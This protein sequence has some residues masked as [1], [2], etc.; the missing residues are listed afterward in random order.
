MEGSCKILLVNGKETPCEAIASTLRDAGYHCDC[1]SS[2][3][4]IPQ[5]I[6]ATP[7]DLLVLDIVESG[8]AGRQLI[9]ET[10]QVAGGLPIILV[11]DRPT[12]ETA[13]DA[14]HLAIVA[15]LVKPL[16]LEQLHL[17]VRRSV[18]RSR[19]H[20]VAADIH[21]RSIHCEDT[22]QKLQE[23]VQQPLSKDV[24]ELVGPMLSTTFSGLVTSVADLRRLLD[25]LVV[26]NRTAAS[27]SET[28]ELLNKLEMVRTAMHEAVGVLEETK[29]AFKSKRLGELRRQLQAVLG[30]LDERQH[31]RKDRI[32]PARPK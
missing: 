5:M 3:A 6:A 1:T 19:L 17:H 26:T 25:C 28:A 15:Y 13:V 9:H 4:D 21:A 27:R 11:T 30:V 14:L 32:P 8:N 16:N 22:A 18:V 12:V 20:R 2:A 29:H 7:Y 31:P 23:L 10:K 24:T